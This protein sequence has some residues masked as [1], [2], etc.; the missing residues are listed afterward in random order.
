MRQVKV[1]YVANDLLM[2]FSFNIKIPGAK[3]FIPWE[4]PA[5]SLNLTEGARQ[6][7]H[8]SFSFEAD[9]QGISMELGV[10]LK[11]AKT[12]KCNAMLASVAFGSSALLPGTIFLID[13]K[14]GLNLAFPVLLDID[15]GFWRVQPMLSP[16]PVFDSVSMAY[17]TQAFCGFAAGNVSGAL[18]NRQ[19]K[20]VKAD[21]EQVRARVTSCAAGK[22]PISPP[23]T[24][25]YRQCGHVTGDSV[26]TFACMAFLRVYQELF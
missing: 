21:L 2:A 8:A 23:L 19:G 4:I 13:A 20:S 16:S 18:C 14:K 12:A 5:I 26:E 25:Q 15:E 7:L 9:M 6:S 24:W 22:A 3:L 1:S 10:A 17:S 11:D